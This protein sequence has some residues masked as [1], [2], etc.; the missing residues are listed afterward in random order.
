MDQPI[1]MHEQQ[2]KDTTALPHNNNES[3]DSITSADYTNTQFNNNTQSRSSDKQLRF[4]DT[5]SQ[6]RNTNDVDSAYEYY[7]IQANSITIKLLSSSVYQLAAGF[8]CGFF[9]TSYLLYHIMRI[10]GKPDQALFDFNTA[11]VTLL[12]LALINL[13]RLTLGGGRARIILLV[14]GAINT[15]FCATY[16]IESL[17]ITYAI[18]GSW[19][20]R[21]QL[22][23][24][25]EWLFSTPLIIILIGNLTTSAPERHKAPAHGAAAN[26]NAVEILFAAPIVGRWGK[27]DTP[28]GCIPLRYVVLADVI[29]LLAGAVC[30]IVPAPFNYLALLLSF[31]TFFITLYGM[32]SYLRLPTLQMPVQ[33][34]GGVSDTDDSSDTSAA[35]SDDEN[36]KKK[37]MPEFLRTRRNN[38]RVLNFMRCWV[39]A[40]FTLFP[41]VWMLAATQC[42]SEHTELWLYFFS[43]LLAKVGLNAGLHALNSN[44]VEEAASLRERL[45]QL[46]LAEQIQQAAQTA[47]EN[48]NQFLRYLFHE[49]RGPLNAVVLGLRDIRDS[50]DNPD[51]VDTVGIMSESLNRVSRLLD[52]ANSLYRFDSGH[53]VLEESAFSMQRLLF[54]TLKMLQ[55]QIVGRKTRVRCRIDDTLPNIVA[56]KYKIQQVIANL[57]NNAIKFGPYRGRI[58]ITAQII[59]DINTPSQQYRSQ[60]MFNGKPLPVRTALKSSDGFEMNQSYN[61]R[62]ARN[63]PVMSSPPLT[64]DMTARNIT[65]DM[66]TR[67]MKA[68]PSIAGR[69]VSEPPVKLTSSSRATQSTN[70]FS[71][72]LS[73][74]PS[75]TDSNPSNSIHR[76]FRLNEYISIRLS[77]RDQGAGISD[78]DKSKLFQPYQHVRSGTSQK[79]NSTGLGLVVSKRIIENL[80]GRLGV[81]TAVGVGSEFYFDIPVKVAAPDSSEDNVDGGDLSDDDAYESYDDN[82]IQDDTLLG[83]YTDPYNQVHNR[84]KSLLGRVK[85]TGLNSS[86]SNSGANSSSQSGSDSQTSNS[87]AQP[88]ILPNDYNTSND[89]NI[90]NDSSEQPH[91]SAPTNLQLPGSNDTTPSIQSRALSPSVIN[92]SDTSSIPDSMSNSQPLTADMLRHRGMA[93]PE[94]PKQHILIVDDVSSNRTLLSKLL[95]K[96]N[97]TCEQASNGQVCVDMVL[98]SPTRYTAILLDHEMP[99]MNGSTAAK[100]IRASGNNV[101]IIGVTGNTLIA[102]QTMF[103]Q[104]GADVILSKPVKI[105][106]LLA[107]IKQYSNKKSLQ[108]SKSISAS[109]S[110]ESTP[111]S[112]LQA[113]VSSSTLSASPAA[114][115]DDI[116]R[117]VDTNSAS[118]STDITHTTGSFNTYT[119][120]ANSISISDSGQPHNPTEQSNVS[121]SMQ[122]LQDIS[123]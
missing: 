107:A 120:S 31:I 27:L 117:V 101:T 5:P 90:I 19:G 77:V 18:D 121:K 29:M 63:H 43:D 52:D 118:A 36:S 64:P 24:Y 71:N 47:N 14:C 69:H 30:D 66:H 83:Y 2:S 9:I 114:I 93:S 102:D 20:R 123:K 42:I 75:D 97:F 10:Y 21:V 84:K 80:N 56:D 81:N 6:S 35:S 1:D 46:Q 87:V 67:A 48:R 62:I 54:R 85:F 25:V 70:R 39:A 37:M 26:A 103:I 68:P 59:H 53:F 95:S 34:S 112:Q 116:P 106:K 11:C 82:G 38:I 96:Q 61:P 57:I 108:I 32:D 22:Q 115:S 13:M 78:E 94:A 86:P 16:I 17:G 33:L 58:V 104:C 110:N 7:S 111:T 50:D 79:G 65:P 23:H 60:P 109:Q 49:I 88:T 76:P 51:F 28:D 73:T 89:N 41:C 72:E 8:L 122:R 4:A 92:S 45:L 55:T 100:Q 105:P 98:S 74:I 3:N 40:T 15:V 99:V 91:S 119:T 113:L 44:A 12:C